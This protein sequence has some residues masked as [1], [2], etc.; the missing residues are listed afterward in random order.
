MCGIIGAFSK[1]DAAS[2]VVSGLVALQ[3]CGQEAF[4]ILS[5]EGNGERF[6]SHRDRGFVN[7]DSAILARLAGSVAIGHV[8][9]S[10]SG[11]NHLRNAQPCFSETRFG[12]IG[13]AH[14]GNLLNADAIRTDNLRSGSRFQST[15]DTEVILDLIAKSGKETFMESL[16]DALGKV[17]GAYSLV[18]LTENRHIIGVRDPRGFHPLS[19][20]KKD[21]CYLLATE[22]C[23]LNEIGAEFIR[24]I[25]P[26]E[27]IDISEFGFLSLFPFEKKACA[28]CIFRQ[29]YFARPDSLVDDLQVS[30]SRYRIGKILAKESPVKYD[31]PDGLSASDVYFVSPVPESGIGAAEGY[32]KVLGLRLKRGLIRKRSYTARTFIQP[33]EA[34]REDGARRK[35]C[36]DNG[37]LFGKKVI[38]VDDSIVRGTTFKLLVKMVRDAGAKEVHIRIASPPFRHH[39]VYG[40]D[41]PSDNELIASKMDIEEMRKFFNADS[42]AFISLEGLHYALGEQNYPKEKTRFCN[43]CFTGNY[44]EL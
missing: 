18:I 8:R 20:G 21:G 34:L 22:T 42:L 40:I 44:P 3:H 37:V 23:A 30:A 7:V 19:L 24:E 39:C 17:K 43:A 12:G 5:Y 31:L 41:T 6:H 35:Y 29:V 25:K 14:N 2:L 27:M 33:S 32:A 10:T 28:H 16:V 38:L 11:G 26:G 15:S 13:I 36:T 4:G 1:N 9:Y